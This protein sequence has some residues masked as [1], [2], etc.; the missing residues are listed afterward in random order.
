M[1]PRPRTR[2]GRARP[3]PPARARQG[4]GTACR[5]RWHRAAVG[6]GP[7]SVRPSASS[8]SHPAATCSALGRLE[9]STTSSSRPE[10]GTATRSVAVW[11]SGKR[12]AALARRSAQRTSAGRTA[13][14]SPANTMAAASRSASDRATRPGDRGSTKAGAP[15]TRT[16]GPSSW[17]RATPPTPVRSYGRTA[18]ATAKGTFVSLCTSTTSASRPSS[19]RA[20]Y[21]RCTA[22]PLGTRRRVSTTGVLPS[23]DWRTAASRAGTC[24]R[25]SAPIHQSSDHPRPATATSPAG[26]TDA[27]HGESRFPTG[28]QGRVRRGCT[29]SSPG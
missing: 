8:A 21:T 24:Q 13:S 11:A 15:S 14:A 28:V 17:I 27:R 10:S 18:S 6:S 25:S 19:P 2:R 26:S 29:Q 1:P 20:V 12:K 7:R 5:R 22:S 3:R 16:S 23:R 4:T 9:G